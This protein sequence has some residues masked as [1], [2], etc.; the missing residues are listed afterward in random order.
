MTNNSTH[1][2]EIFIPKKKKKKFILKLEFY[3][4]DFIRLTNKIS[5]MKDHL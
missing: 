1:W 2:R 3:P 5:V 4:V